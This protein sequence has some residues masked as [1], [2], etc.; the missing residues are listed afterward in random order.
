MPCIHQSKMWYVIPV[1]PRSRS[2]FV[3]AQVKDIANPIISS[4]EDIEEDA[5]EV[6]EMEASPSSNHSTDDEEEGD[7]NESM[8]NASDNESIN[9]FVNL[10][11][12]GF[13]M[14]IS[15][16]RDLLANED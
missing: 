10:A 4:E 6:K 3:E 13:D 14:D 11:T 8:G 1:T 2:I 12:M 9:F 5:I 16:C 7:D 15:A